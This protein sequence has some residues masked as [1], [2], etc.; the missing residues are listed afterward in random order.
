M[1]KSASVVKKA[2]GQTKEKIDA[3]GFN[4]VVA[5]ARLLGLRLTGSNLNVKP[6]AIAEERDKWTYN[7]AAA[8]ED[9]HLDC[10][11]RTLRGYFAYKVAC[12]ENRRRPVT[13]SATYLATY[14]LS[15]DCVEESAIAFLNRVGRFSAYP[16]FRALFAILTEQSGLQLPPLPVM[17][18]PPR[19]VK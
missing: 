12:V 17:H 5:S 19:L 13:L 2:S 11:T 1:S 3:A 4:E 16:Y 7:I 9:W 6:E 10:D 8:L 14:R 18:E 15:R